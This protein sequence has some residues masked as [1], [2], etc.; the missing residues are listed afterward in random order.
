METININGTQINLNILLPEDYEVTFNNSATGLKKVLE[1]E[2]LLIRPKSKMISVKWVAYDETPNG[3]KINRQEMNRVI[4]TPEDYD[5][6]N[7]AFGGSIKKF[8]I[9]GLFR[10]VMARF[11]LFSH[12]V[13]HSDLTLIENQPVPAPV[14]DPV[15][16]IDISDAFNDPE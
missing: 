3:T 1:C 11:G 7:Q 9:N 6:F 5:F 15:D 16:D 10:Q 8:S 2:E 13:Y 4:S 14:P 12:Q